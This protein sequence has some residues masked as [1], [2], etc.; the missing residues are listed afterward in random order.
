MVTPY[1][2][3]DKYRTQVGDSGE[4]TVDKRAWQIRAMGNTVN[5]QQLRTSARTINLDLTVVSRG[6]S[7]LR[8]AEPHHQ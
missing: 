2:S 7:A 3:R 6:F 5:R 4:V 8:S 1:N